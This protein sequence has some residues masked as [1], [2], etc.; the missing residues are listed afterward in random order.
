MYQI[1]LIWHFC[2]NIVTRV[3]FL[4]HMIGPCLS[5]GRVFDNVIGLCESCDVLH[6]DTS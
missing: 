3:L 4:S 6:Q 5:R 2:D 1:L